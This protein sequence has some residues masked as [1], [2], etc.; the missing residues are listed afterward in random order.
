[1]EKDRKL[2]NYE[3]LTIGLGSLICYAI[4]FLQ[5]KYLGIEAVA[6]LT[7][8]ITSIFLI[9]CNNSKKRR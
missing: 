1:M 7:I 4:G 5:G 6:I 3:F 2:S 9:A 8:I